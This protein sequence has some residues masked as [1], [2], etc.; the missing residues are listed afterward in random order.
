MSSVL[1]SAAPTSANVSRKRTT[2][3]FRSGCW[4]F[5]Q[6]LAAPRARA[7]VDPPQPVAGLPRRTSANSIPVALRARHLV[8]DEHLRLV[9]GQQRVQRLDARV[10]A[11][12]S[13][14]AGLRLPGVEAERI[15]GAHEH[16]ADARTRPSGRSAAAARATASRPAASR[17]ARRLRPD[18]RQ[19]VGS[20]EQDIGPRGAVRR[21]QASIVAPTCSS[22]STR[23]RSMRSSTS[24]CG[25]RAS[26]GADERGERERSRERNELH[27]AGREPRDSRSAAR[28]A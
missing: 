9:R 28:A 14:A 1:R 3:V 18:R 15:A 2:S 4:S 27:P 16:R 12:S 19:L 6:R 20:D 25:S 24:I 21:R 8:A 10:D 22:S 11:E 7:P 26:A 5:T 23:S 13:R 17:D